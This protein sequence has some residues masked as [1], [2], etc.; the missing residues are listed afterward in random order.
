MPTTRRSF[1]TRGLASTCA[2]AA[3]GATTGMCRAERRPAGEA[4]AEDAGPRPLDYGLS[5]LCNPSPANAVRFWIESR[6]TL[7][8]DSSG[9]RVDF[10]QCASCKSE[11]TFAEKDLFQADNY[12]FLPIFGG[13][14]AADLL[15]FRRPARLS[16]RYREVTR[17]EDVWGKPI[18]KLRE[19]RPVQV[20]DTWEAIRDATA[21]AVPIVTQTEIANAET[22]LRAIIECPVKTMN[23]SL[24]RRMY[25]VDTGPVAFPDLSRRFDPWIDCLHLAFVAFNAPH[26]ADFVIEQPTPVVEGEKEVC[27]IYHYSSPISLPAKNTVLAVGP[28]GG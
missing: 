10:Y 26:F 24:D 1:L 13:E 6:T 25:Q 14:E 7:V 16:E 23:V 28:A 9:E 3:T 17:S 2:V 11:H 22:G 21:A 8:D 20:L 4:P 12:D 15:I 18:L 27:Q 19:G 5:F